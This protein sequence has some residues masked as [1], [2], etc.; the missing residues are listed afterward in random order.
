MEADERMQYCLHDQELADAMEDTLA[1]ICLT[2]D[3]G[4]VDPE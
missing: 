4:G 1:E 3:H 2:K